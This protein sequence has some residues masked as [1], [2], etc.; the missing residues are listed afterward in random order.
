VEEFLESENRV[1]Q[2]SAE[3]A[4]SRRRLDEEIANHQRTAQALQHSELLVGKLNEMLETHV[5]ERTTELTATV[6][7]LESFSYSISHDLRA[8]LRAISGYA[9]MLRE[10]H[11]S[12]LG[13]DGNSLLIR[14]EASVG[15]MAR[16][17]DGLLAF[18]RLGRMQ[19]DAGEVDTLE[20]V[21][22][23]VLELQSEPGGHS[24]RFTIDALPSVRGD[25]TML[26]QVWINLLS[27]AIKFSSRNPEPR[28][29][30]SAAQQA[31]EVVFSVCD[32]GVGFDRKY[33][34]KLFEVF[35]RLHAADE[36]PGVGVGLAIVRR[37]VVRHG[38]RVW[39]DSNDNGGATFFFSLPIGQ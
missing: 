11:A 23:V 9:A 36:F 12:M 2:L 3:L 22:S 1:V 19:P 7:E 25:A 21:N 28:I 37:I 8:P 34:S 39:A 30:I 13:N 18:S 15:R 35:N 31:S 6:A 17:I 26:R 5:A 32:N 14:I 10:D 38:G 29:G 16:L 4:E 24:A 27:N 33:A 20:M